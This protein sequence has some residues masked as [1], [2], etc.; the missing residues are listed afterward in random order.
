MYSK[1]SIPKYMPHILISWFW[2]VETSPIDNQTIKTDP[3]LKWL[4]LNAMDQKL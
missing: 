3:Y 2:V 4:I 1:M